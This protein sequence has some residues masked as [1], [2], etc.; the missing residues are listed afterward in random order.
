MYTIVGTFKDGTRFLCELDPPGGN[1][2]D[3][4]KHPISNLRE[5]LRQLDTLRGMFLGIRY[6]L[7]Q[8]EEVK[9]DL[10]T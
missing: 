7:Y 5:A 3:D 8:L 2:K 1:V 4:Y 10:D 9:D 6:K